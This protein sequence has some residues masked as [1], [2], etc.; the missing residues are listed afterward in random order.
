MK[1]FV[2]W[3]VK[4]SF[5]D[6]LSHLTDNSRGCFVV[7]QTEWFVEIDLYEIFVNN[8]DRMNF[9]GLITSISRELF[10]I[11]WINLQNVYIN[12]SANEHEINIMF[13]YKNDIKLDITGFLSNWGIIA[14]STFNWLIMVERDQISSLYVN[15]QISKSICKI[16]EYIKYVEWK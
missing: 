8:I 13:S 15:L 14:Y 1:N 9:N 6:K 5:E 3:L 16:F 2:D 7:Q 4:T 10:N 12:K 11:F